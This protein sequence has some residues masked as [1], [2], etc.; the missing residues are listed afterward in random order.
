[1]LPWNA[2]LGSYITGFHLN[3]FVTLK[4]GV[5]ELRCELDFFLFVKPLIISQNLIYN[6]IKSKRWLQN[7]QQQQHLWEDN[8]EKKKKKP[9][10]AVCP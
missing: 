5:Y 2:Q 3:C 6:L 8:G 9:V 10:H 4:K 1:M 7:T